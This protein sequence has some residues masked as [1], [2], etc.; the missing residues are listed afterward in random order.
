MNLQNFDLKTEFDC[1]CGKTHR[2][3]PDD[4]IVGKGVI[5][6]LPE[7]AARYGAKKIFLLADENTY[8]AAGKRVE[9]I[10]RGA[11][12][13]V[14]R[15]LFGKEPVK[16]DERAVGAAVLHFDAS[17]DRIIGVGSGVI[18][19]IGKLLA[20]TAKRPY[21]IVGT[22]PSMDG[23][24]SASSSMERDGLK[25]SVP[26]VCPN[27]I[28]GDTDVLK[29]A[30]MRML[31]AGLGDMIAKYV[32]IAEWRISHLINGE[33]YCETVAS[34]VRAARDL[35]VRHADG[36]LRRDEEA[37]GA[38]FEGLVIGGLAMNYAGVSRPASGVEHY[39][40]HIWDMR[41]LEFG[42]PV[43]FHGIQCAIGTLLAARVYEKLKEITPDRAAACAHAEAF[44]Y[45]KWSETLRALLG[46]GAEAMIALEEKE[47]KYD[48]AAHHARLDGI[49]GKWDAILRVIDEEIP[50]SAEIEALLDRIGAPKS[51]AEIGTEAHL[52]TVFAAT[53]DIRDKYVLSRLLWDLGVTAKET[54]FFA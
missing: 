12:I 43:D 18:N 19:D 30:P 36:L 13:A 15:Y 6:R 3:G 17:C 28:L 7:L 20:K 22:A 54:D 50:A 41:G 32:S 31:W 1:A 53:K 40:S 35:C 8:A 11:G 45:G 9:E 2:A 10:L 26:S 42:T 4:V 33:Y 52:S 44:D 16:P 49:L 14:S 23:Y 27:V 29:K 5:A 47:Q 39:I 21:L 34:L 51:P 37:V 46:R 48:V 25:V 38:V 24:A